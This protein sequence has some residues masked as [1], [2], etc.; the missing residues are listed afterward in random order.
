MPLVRSVTS[1]ARSTCMSGPVLAF[2]EP[3]AL[4]RVVDDPTMVGT[5]RTIR[6]CR[7]F[8]SRRRGEEAALTM[9]AGAEQALV[10]LPDG[11]DTF[12]KSCWW[13]VVV[14]WDVRE[15][16]MWTP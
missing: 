7:K 2:V 3:Y 10:W 5:I 11:E 15:R 13:A 6:S 12:C 16:M 4:E 9:C 1:W 14:E 8:G